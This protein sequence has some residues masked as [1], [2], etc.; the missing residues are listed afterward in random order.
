MD[1]KY[2]IFKFASLINSISGGRLESNECER[3]AELLVNDYYGTL[4][5][6]F[7]IPIEKELPDF[8]APLLF[9]LQN[10]N[11]LTNC[12]SSSKKFNGFLYFVNKKKITH[13]MYLTDVRHP[14]T[15]NRVYLIKYNDIL[16]YVQAKTFVAACKKKK[17]NINDCE[18]IE[19]F[20]QSFI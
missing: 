7:L 8:T 11:Y 17:F 12:I 3:I 2:R 10:G 16:H 14:L 6:N 13:W 5:E 18:L 9:R 15:Y 19:V 1:K 20:N 4:F